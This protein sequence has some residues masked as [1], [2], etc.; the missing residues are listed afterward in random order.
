[1]LFNNSL[2]EFHISVTNKIK[3][4]ISSML[5]TFIF[6][7]IIWKT[8]EPKKD[9]KYKSILFQRQEIWR[10]YC[11]GAKVSHLAKQFNVSCP[12]IYKILKR[13]RKRN[14]TI[15]KSTNHRYRCV[16]YWFIRLTKVEEKILKQK[17]KEA[18]RYNKSYPWELMHID[19]KLLPPIKWSKKKEYLIEAVMTDNWRKYHL[20]ED[21]EFIK[22]Y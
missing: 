10:L 22:V 9:Q 2:I 19:T 15:H 16:Y 21:H 1:M 6:K 5:R 20:T 18:K 3:N 11:S 7:G 13:A 17:N 12:I 14:F 4:Q 8:L